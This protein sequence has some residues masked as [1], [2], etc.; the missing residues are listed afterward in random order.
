MATLNRLEENWDKISPLLLKEWDRLNDADL[1]WTEKK[2]DRLV[3]VIHDRY[4]GRTEII[5][6]AAIRNRVNQLLRQVEA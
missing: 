4:G 3:E 6:E 1:L 5:Q 2:F